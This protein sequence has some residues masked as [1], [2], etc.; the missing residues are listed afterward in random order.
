MTIDPI[1]IGP[2][3]ID[4]LLDYIT[5]R[6]L[7]QFT[8]V[9]DDHTFA[10]L[11][12]RVQAALTAGG[13][14]LTAIV[15]AGD[16]VI[17]DERYLVQVLA[18]AP[19]AD[20]VFLAVGSGTLTDI[21][22]FVSHRTRNP[23]ISLPTA[24][25][26]DGYASIGAPLVLGGVKQ[27]VIGQ[28]PLAIFADLPTLQAAPRPLIAAGF[29][30]MMGKI[31][32]LA[33]WELGHLLGDE[34]YDE[35]IARRARN[36]LRACLDQIEAIAAG[37]QTGIHHLMDGLIESGLCMLAFGD[38]RPASGAEHHSS[39]YWE[40]MLLQG[41]RPP[42]LHGAKV[43][44]ATTLVADRYARLRAMS[45]VEMDR[46]LK[47]ATPPDRAQELAT[48]RA[49]YGP[50]AETVIAAQARFLNMTAADFA[51][52]KQHVL[53]RWEAIQAI[54]AAVPPG[55]AIA[56][57][58]RQVGALTSGE[59]LGLSEDEVRRGLLYGHYLRDRLT[60]LKLFHLLGLEVI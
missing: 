35:A 36:G 13:F 21:T 18:A 12:E 24:P 26:V 17:A 32:S 34:P 39:H 22:R 31:T 16:P 1:Y 28:P 57:M 37:D 45:R 30:D 3:A 23:F 58:L 49:A 9:A 8:L 27:T 25:S 59:A 29:G 42:I 40:M 50:V 51:R 48:I 11:G 33:D 38:S 47:A 19:V 60:I 44:L 46:R 55:E 56:G 54:A 7:R 20:Q 15:L 52:L 6:G 5:R 4:R 2:Q 14:D 10:A 53:D 43:G 41:N